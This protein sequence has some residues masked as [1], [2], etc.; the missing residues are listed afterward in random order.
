MK[1]GVSPVEP[2]VLLVA[3][4]ET[5]V[6]ARSNQID[7]LPVAARWWSNPQPRVVIPS[8]WAAGFT[9]RRAVR[10]LTSAQSLGWVPGANA[11]AGVHI[12]PGIDSGGGSRRVAG[13]LRSLDLC[14]R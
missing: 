11:A 7:R 9:R 1:A 5:V 2:T 3:R 12:R 13:R 10:L 8:A 6:G 4:P 14:S